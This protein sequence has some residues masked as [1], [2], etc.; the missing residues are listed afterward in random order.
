[1]SRVRKTSDAGMAF[2]PAS[3]GLGSF[4]SLPFSF[5]SDI[6]KRGGP[7]FDGSPAPSG[8][9]VS[10]PE[11]GVPS[12]LSRVSPGIAGSTIAGAGIAG[13]VTGGDVAVLPGACGT[14]TSGIV[15]AGRGN[16]G[17]DTGGPISC[18]PS[19]GSGSVGGT[20]WGGVAGVAAGA[21]GGPRVG[22]SS[23]N[24]P[25]ALSVN[26]QQ[27]IARSAK[28]RLTRNDPHSTAASPFAE[29]PVIRKD[30]LSVSVVR[31]VAVATCCVS[32]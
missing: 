21:G 12:G 31:I 17:A 9:G 32:A 20:V 10:E 16:L 28:L 6:R 30:T 8:T 24:S 23:A 22:S 27:R 15:V 25:A 19:A 4:L 7:G 29:S 26:A 14:G 13:S 5:S 18:G 3:I 2:V 11:N 1:M